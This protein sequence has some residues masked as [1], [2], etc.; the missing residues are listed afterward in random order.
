MRMKYDKASLLKMADEFDNIATGM[1]KLA[2]GMKTDQDIGPML[3]PTVEG[4]FVSLRYMFNSMGNDQPE[5]EV[6]LQ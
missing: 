3:K 6:K 4:L 2:D 5:P 1:R